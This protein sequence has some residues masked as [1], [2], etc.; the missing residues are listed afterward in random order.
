[1]TFQNYIKNSTKTKVCQAIA[2]QNSLLRKG[3]TLQNSRFFCTATMSWEPLHSGAL[4]VNL[5]VES[6]FAKLTKD[7]QGGGEPSTFA[8]GWTRRQGC[9]I[10]P[11]SK[12]FKS[13]WRRPASNIYVYW[14]QLWFLELALFSPRIKGRITIFRRELLNSRR[15]N[16]N[17]R[18]SFP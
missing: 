18:L 14:I 7:S 5:S 10:F 11:I 17:S 2:C 12:V 15:E 13:C 4:Q 8:S 1:M 6:T 3:T 16:D 9:C